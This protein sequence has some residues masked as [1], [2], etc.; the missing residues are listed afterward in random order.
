VGSIS[1]KTFLTLA[2][3]AFDLRPGAGAMIIASTQPRDAASVDEYRQAEICR[4]VSIVRHAP[5]KDAF[6]ESPTTAADQFIVARGK[7]KTVIAVI[8]G[9]AIGAETP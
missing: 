3:C 2:S 7:Q 9:L 4:R 6:V 1:Q 5:M 8:T